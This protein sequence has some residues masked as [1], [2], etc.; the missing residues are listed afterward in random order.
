MVLLSNMSLLNVP[1]DETQAPAFDLAET[2][3]P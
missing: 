1:E 2:S 3:A